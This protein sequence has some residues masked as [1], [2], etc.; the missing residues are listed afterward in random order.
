MSKKPDMDQEEL[1][2]PNAEKEMTP[3]EYA[4]ARDKAVAHIESELPYLEAEEKYQRLSAD[5]EDHKTRKIV[6][7]ARRAQF[8]AQQNPEGAEQPPQEQKPEGGPK[9]GPRPLKKD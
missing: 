7:I 3:E 8:F 2:D 9:K 4:E 5:I 1:I 6:A